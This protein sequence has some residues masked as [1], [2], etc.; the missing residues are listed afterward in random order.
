MRGADFLEECPEELEAGD[1]DVPILALASRRGE[2]GGYAHAEQGVADELVR[3][4]IPRGDDDLGA[5][6]VLADAAIAV[7]HTSEPGGDQPLG[8]CQNAALD[9]SQRLTEEQV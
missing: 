9:G 7:E 8:E 3:G 2:A 1:D 5:S 4:A 6:R